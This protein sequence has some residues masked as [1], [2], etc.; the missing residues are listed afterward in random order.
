[1]R[2][3]YIL[4]GITTGLLTL[5]ALAAA[6]QTPAWTW[7]IQT[8]GALSEHV[9]QMV[10]AQD[11]S[12]Y[13]LGQF[14]DSFEFGDLVV[15]HPGAPGSGARF[16]LKISSTGEAEWAHTFEMNFTT[17]AYF[18]SP[19]ALATDSEGNVY[20]AGGIVRVTATGAFEAEVGGMSLTIPSSAESGDS[21]IA[22]LDSEGIGV[23]AEN[24][25]TEEHPVL[26]N[27]DEIIIDEFDR[28]YWSCNF[29]SYSYTLEIND[30]IHYSIGGEDNLT[31]SILLMQLNTDGDFEWVRF[32][33]SASN[34]IG[35][36]MVV[37]AGGG[38]F[39]SAAWNADTVY[40]AGL[41]AVN[42]DPLL[43]GNSDRW[44][45]KIDHNGDAEWLIHE[46][47]Q[48]NQG[49]ARILGTP[50]G[51][52]IAFSRTII[53]ASIILNEVEYSE[54][55]GMLVTKYDETGTLEHVE[56]FPEMPWLQTLTTDGNGSYYL[57]F[58]F[59]A[60]AFSFSG[61]DFVNSGFGSS[62]FMVACIDESIA[63]VWAIAL[64][65]EENDI[66]RNL[67]FDHSNGL[68]AGGNFNSQNLI[69]GD[70][71][72]ENSGLFTDDI[73]IAALDFATSIAA[74]PELKQLRAYPNPALSHLHFDLTSLKTRPYT[75]RVFDARGVP[76]K[77][78]TVTGGEVAQM[79]VGG[80]EAGTYIILIQT[81]ED[82]FFSKFIKL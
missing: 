6:G 13:V 5:F 3:T 71:V 54:P 1:M 49:F 19:Y 10:V 48:G 82:V 31:G 29:L 51:G 64:G 80:L 9:D 8:E 35:K 28:I 34:D 37:A 68:I 57:G 18:I 40:V 15:T 12:I 63:P 44:I 78:M 14:T 20:I 59:Q 52:V 2:A 55:W 36:G 7:A 65:A 25:S 76:M 33:G 45:A 53:N 81:T 62:D 66:L 72:L 75:A 74:Q 38:V 32:I 46:G 56:F 43:T 24:L 21:F 4:N 60:D 26:T 77:S 42:P 73:F 47:G 23:W 67:A 50:Q 22:K 30:E 41:T 69:F 11:G 17:A 39:M 61:F 70:H 16:L 58:N 79:D 27:G